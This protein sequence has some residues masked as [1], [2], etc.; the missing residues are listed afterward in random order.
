[1]QNQFR[2][3]TLMIGLMLLQACHHPTN[4]KPISA[5]QM[6]DLSELSS[7]QFKGKMSFSDGQDGG[8]GSIQWQNNG[9]LIS[10][11]LKA[12][13][14][15]KSWHLTEQKVGA[16][17]ISNG[18]TLI[19]D[20]GQTLIS[21][22]LGWQVPWQHLKSW[23]LGRPHNQNQGQVT[24]QTDGFIIQEGGWQIEYSRLKTYSDDSSKQLPHKI[25]ARKNNYSIKLAIK[26]W[27]W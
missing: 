3:I 16:Q 14:G 22:Q 17:L 15:S 1:M 5:S 8:S 19:A 13:L 7:Y 6:I 23:V 12:P 25:V 18:A 20:S 27:L 4:V 11:R 9:G 24:W 10:A 2:L 21:D 26:Q